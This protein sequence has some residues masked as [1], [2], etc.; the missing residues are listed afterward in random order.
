MK[1][2]PSCSSCARYGPGS[3]TD[4]SMCGKDK[5][6]LGAACSEHER[7]ELDPKEPFEIE[8]YIKEVK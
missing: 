6:G 4:R 2:I 1:K 3:P 5:W 8:P 7:R